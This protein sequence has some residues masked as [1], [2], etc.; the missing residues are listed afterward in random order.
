MLSNINLL[1]N[2]RDVILTEKLENDLL[3][4]QTLDLLDG[5]AST[6]EIDRV[7]KYMQELEQITKLKVGLRLRW[8]RLD[9]MVQRR[10]SDKDLVCVLL[11]CFVLMSIGVFL[12]SIVLFYRK[13]VR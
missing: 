11:I 3:G 6:S 1:R 13:L 5:N 10:S 9:R 7:Y 12:Q 8:N 2:E 4:R